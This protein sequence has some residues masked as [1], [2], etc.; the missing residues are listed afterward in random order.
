MQLY[1]GLRDSHYQR[2]LFTTPCLQPAT[3]AEAL[4]R[5]YP[6]PNWE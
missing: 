4:M 2:Q 3:H 1:G 5:G 6:E